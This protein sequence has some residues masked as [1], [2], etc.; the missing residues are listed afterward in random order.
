MAV[1]YLTH[2]LETILHAVQSCGFDRVRLYLM[3]E[4]KCF[5]EGHIQVG[6]EREFSGFKISVDNIY[7]QELLADHQPHVFFNDIENLLL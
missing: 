3:S 6:M 4:D 7:V 1:V 2:V 5:M